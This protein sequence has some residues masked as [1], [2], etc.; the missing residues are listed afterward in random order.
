MW[1]WMVHPEDHGGL[2]DMALQELES[3]SVLC[4][5]A[6]TVILVD[7]TPRLHKIRLPCH[8]SDIRL[9][10]VSCPGPWVEL[11]Y[12]GPCCTK[13]LFGKAQACLDARSEDLYFRLLFGYY[14]STKFP[15]ITCAS[16]V[17]NRVKLYYPWNVFN[18]QRLEP[19]SLDM[20]EYRQETSL[21]RTWRVLLP[22]LI[23]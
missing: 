3:S 7:I 8:Q 22:G 17:R 13:I 18:Y 15:T 21:F 4:T 6:V 2:V 23:S 11:I 9:H 1:E 10:C 20:V 14:Y 12:G 5:T 16:H 19:G